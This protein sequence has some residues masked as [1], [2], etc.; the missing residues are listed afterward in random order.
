LKEKAMNWD[1]VEGKWKELRGKARAKWG[2]ITDDEL[3][4]AA[5]RRDKLVGL[6]QQRYGRAKDVAEREADE[7]LRMQ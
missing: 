1:Q 7:W 6:I 5:G 4:S 3:E 2:D